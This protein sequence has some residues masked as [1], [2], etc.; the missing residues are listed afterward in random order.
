VSPDIYT[1]AWTLS[2]GDFKGGGEGQSFSATNSVSSPGRYDLKADFTGTRKDCTN[3]TCHASGT[4]NC[5]VYQLT[6]TEDKLWLGLD[7]TDIGTNKFGTG[8][9]ALF[10]P[11]PWTNAWA[12]TGVCILS[13]MVGNTAQYWTKGKE[14]C[15]ESYL[16]QILKCTA[17]VTNPPPDFSLSA[18]TN[19]TVVRVDVAIAGTSEETEE[20]VGAKALFFE[21]NPDGTL[22]SL[23]KTNMVGV[24]ITCTPA[25]LPYGERVT[26][27]APVDSLYV[28]DG[29]NYVAAVESY[30]ASEINSKEFFIHGHDVTAF[31]IVVTH[32]ASQAKDKA[33]VTVSNNPLGKGECEA[34]AKCV[35]GAQIANRSIYFA[36]DFG[37]TPWVAGAPSG[38]FRVHEKV[39]TDRLG[40]LAMFKYDHP[41]NRRIVSRH[42]ATGYIAI[43][44]SQDLLVSYRNGK[45]AD[46]SS[47]Q[48]MQCV[49]GADGLVTEI[50]PDRTR[51][52]Y[53][54]DNAVLKL[55]TPDGV[56]VLAADLGIK[57]IRTAGGIRQVWSKTDGLLDAVQSPYAPE[58]V[59]SWY[60]P[61]AVDPQPD[62]SGLYTFTGAPAKT[63]TFS[64]T[65]QAYYKWVSGPECPICAAGIHP[66]IPCA[67]G[68]TYALS[69]VNYGLTLDERRGAE[70]I[71]SYEWK[72]DRYDNDWTFTKG[73]GNDFIKD[74]LIHIRAPGTSTVTRVRTDISGRISTH[75]KKVYLND[76]YGARLVRRSSVGS[77]GAER[78]SYSA[79]A[80]TN[81]ALVGRMASDVNEYGNATIYEHDAYGRV[82]SE[83][84]T[85]AGGIA[86]VTSYG[87]SDAPD[88]QGFI[89]RR[90]TIMVVYQNGVLTSCTDYSYKGA[91]A[92]NG[93]GVLGLC[94]TV[95]RRD[96]KTQISLK[97]YTH[98]YSATSGNAI[99]R[100]RV[101][102]TVNPDGSATHYAYA[103]DDNSWT[104]TVTQGY[105]TA[106]GTGVTD[107]DQLFSA[108]P[109]KSART[110]NT[111]DFRGDVVLTESYVNTGSV[112]TRAGWTTNSYNIMHKQLGSARHDGTSEMS[113][114]I[115]TGPVWQRNADGTSVTNTFDTAKRIKTSTHYTPFGNVKTTYNYDAEGRVV[116]QSVATNGIAVGMAGSS[117]Y[118]TE[119]RILLSV[120]TQ[121]RTNRTSYSADNLVVTR[122]DP[123]GAIVVDIN[124]TYGS[125]LCRTGTVMRA[126]YYTQGVD[127]TTGTRWEK[128]TYGSP[129]GTDYTKSYYNAL[130]QLVLQ[131][132]PGFGGATLKSV[133]AYNTKGQLESET[134]LVQ[135]GTG[136]YDLPAT[137]YAYN[138]LGDRIATTQAVGT[139]SRIQSSDNTFS[140]DNNIVQQTSISVASCSDATI[141]PMTNAV[142]T[143]LWPLGDDAAGLLAE[144]RSRDVRGNET[145]Q[146]VVQNSTTYERTT[147]VSNATSVLPAISRSLAGLTTSS[148]DQH[149]CTMIYGYDALMRQ[150]R[151]ETLSGNAD[152]R[153]VGSYTHYN[154]IGQVAYTEDAFGSRTVYGYDSTGRRISSTQHGKATDPVL[155]TYTAYD[156]ANRT[157]ATWG[158]TYPV[159]YEYDTAGR[160]IA[161]YTYRGTAAV[162]SYSDIAA[163]KPQMDRTQWLYDQATGLLTNKLYADGMG[164]SYSYTALGQ[165]SARKWARLSSTGQQLLTLYGYDSF[166]SLTNTA[167]SDGTPSISFTLNALGQMKTVTDGSGT[168]TLDYASDGQMLA[169]QLAFSTSLFTLHEKFDTLGRNQGYAL[170]NGVVQITGTMQSYDQYGRLDQVAVDG[171]GGEFTY[172][173]LAGSHLQKTLAMPNGV[174]RT[175]GYESNRDLRTSIIHSNATE[176][177]VQRDFGFEGLARLQDRTVFRAGGTPV[178]PDAFG[179]NIR[180]ELTNA[181]IGANAFAY[182]FDPIGNRLEASEFG[183]NTA[184][185]ANYLN[186]YTGITNSVDSVPLCE[187]SPEFDEDGNQTLLRTTT[188]IWHV[189][190]NA[191]NRPVLFSNETTVVSMV[192]DYMGRRSEYKETVNNTL[193]RHERY[194]YRGYLQIAA[195]DMLNSASVKHTIVWDPSE[196]VAT[197]PLALQIGTVACYYSF[198]QVKN[199]TEL[200]DSAGAI[201]ATYDY[202]PFGQ[203][204]ASTGTISNP[205]TFSSEIYDSTLGLQ[206]YNYRH[207]NLLD[208][209]W[210]NRDPLTQYENDN[211]YCCAANN[212]IDQFDIF[213]LLAT[214]ER[215]KTDALS[216]NCGGFLGLFTTKAGTIT[217]SYYDI[218]SGTALGEDNEYSI[219]LA[220]VRLKMDFKEENSCCCP[221]GDYRW[222]QWVVKDTDPGNKKTVPYV[223]AEIPP[224]YSPSSSYKDEPEV[225]LHNLF[226]LNAPLRPTEIE[227]RFKTQLVCVEGSKDKVLKTI[228][229]GFKV[230]RLKKKSKD[231]LWYEINLF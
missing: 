115:C 39:S 74:R 162:S 109:G 29:T 14:S 220:K 112:F 43:L 100:G 98:Y 76:R 67:C 164:P 56:E 17:T 59:V 28:K 12:H 138:Q 70:F 149:G 176:R 37:R 137:S 78:L 144:S 108:L 31:E 71:F 77:D 30:E 211:L 117:V 119:G 63:F 160:M 142:I 161:M 178:G 52:V 104:E 140:V 69:G 32:P 179:Y 44:D 225:Y 18:S 99:E 180:S 177:L 25:N 173:Y 145:V 130:N 101:R 219:R 186:Q 123:A 5:T 13:N 181:V 153:L 79:D 150:I 66:Y 48:D 81:A 210:L 95:A 125:L 72:F 141:L 87:Y 202:S 33:K 42:D 223:D 175:F 54:A 182:D 62:A 131:E 135:G 134:R 200:F 94:D 156:S 10:P 208:G 136:T 113:N 216:V 229:W 97:S 171:I 35:L 73:I 50:L 40:R 217:Y 93:S 36:Q 45:P 61:S 143:R 139:V 159:V 82:T 155:T 23:A 118:D 183:T 201:A 151:A 214:T 68:S 15:S 60:P 198:D 129:T 4:T 8:T 84:T 9:A 47:G 127:A 64:R 204:V 85:V 27:E 188:G 174:T 166:G 89:D 58:T 75:E 226:S 46:E 157:L 91:F 148:T 83:S 103:G 209:R 205:I 132:R 185:A 114:W 206:Y 189:T 215:D 110:V 111:H 187:F 227:V 51:I 7:R 194:L 20:A 169:E 55:V 38:L 122:I 11:D 86:Q 21:D 124:D 120:D 230:K 105:L 191:E 222:K 218:S 154:A 212:C 147:T 203:L 163:L 195:L 170:S 121:G 90:P 3:C 57:V 2:P 190:Y 1:N 168:R 152:E 213:G 193:T 126:E 116:S 22:S 6:V 65:S 158:A 106:P 128:T 184:Y 88:A 192:Y 96:P 196:P 231:G 92:V 165:L 224:Y 41:M 199:V 53:G 24:S 228:N 19:F 80:I 172:G 133:Y 107:L 26:I 146:K 49:I 167:Y 207:L 197:R 16:D 102:L 34:C 221:S